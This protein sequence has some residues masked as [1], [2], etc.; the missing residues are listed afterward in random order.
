MAGPPAPL[1]EMLTA[2]QEPETYYSDA[3]VHRALT[4]DG[5]GYLNFLN[6]HLAAIGAGRASCELPAKQLFDFGEGGDFRV[7]PCVLTT[8]EGVIHKAV[9]LVGTNLRQRTVPRQITVGQAFLLDAAE[10][11]IR[12]R[13]AGC[14]L[15]SARTG[16]YAALATRHLLPD[17]R[18]AVLIGAG[19]V[20]YYAARY[21]I[22]AAPLRELAIADRDAA[23]SQALA[24]TLA[25]ETA[26]LA[27]APRI[28]PSVGSAIENTDL[29]ILATDSRAPVYDPDRF[30]ARLVIA[31]GADT[32][33][34]RELA[35]HYRVPKRIF[36][37]SADSLR[38]GD[39]LAWQQ[40]GR[41]AQTDLVELT[42]LCAGAGGELPGRQSPEPRLFVATGSALLDCLT[43]VY[44]ARDT[45]GR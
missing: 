16:A 34:Q 45:P 27:A 9:K 5:P 38:F 40:S 19:R 28:L 1:P 7:M 14:L 31:L 6:R 37:D 15:S 8:A 29:L 35:D 17:A 42:A 12:H 20:G 23:R 2:D 39:L 10:N 43:M 4:R 21:C 26:H 33:H 13:F 24:E 36:V 44:L 25:E 41:L 30:A 22:E 32:P 11:F 18:R 3:A